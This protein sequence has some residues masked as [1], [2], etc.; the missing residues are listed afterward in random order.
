M[1]VRLFFIYA[2]SLYLVLIVHEWIHLL[3]AKLLKY[4]AYIK[5]INPLAFQVVYPNQHR[6]FDNLLI[7]GSSPLIL[8]VIGCFMPLNFYTIIVKLASLSNFFNLLPITG[9]GEIILLSILQIYKG[10]KGEGVKKIFRKLLIVFF[11]GAAL[12][13]IYMIA[14]E[15]ESE[16]LYHDAT[17][18][19]VHRVPEEILHDLVNKKQG[20]YYFGFPECPW[21]IEL[22]PI[23]DKELARAKGTAYVVNTRADH[24]TE[25]DDELLTDFYVQYTKEADLSVPFVVAINHSGDVKV[26]SGTLD[27]HNAAERK[28]TSQQTERLSHLMDELIHFGLQ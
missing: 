4:K 16:A 3:V 21:C 22:L 18:Q 23:L 6:P 25:E 10:R 11:F 20:V 28:L 12:L 19:F 15:Q 13:G 26:H 27:A 9:D 5:R 1:I 2:A 7:A 17:E 24:Y 14:M 8:F